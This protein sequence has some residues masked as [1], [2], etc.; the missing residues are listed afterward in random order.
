[1]TLIDVIAQKQWA[2]FA[3]LY[4]CWRLFFLSRLRSIRTS[5]RLH[6]G[7]ETETLSLRSIRSRLA[8]F[9]IGFLT[10]RF[11]ASFDFKGTGY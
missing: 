5:W 7:V 2:P 10:E 4:I 1:M 11:V 3:Q 8:D 6:P 9:Y